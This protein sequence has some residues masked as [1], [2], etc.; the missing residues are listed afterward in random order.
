MR[1][2]WIE[3][4][5]WWA[6]AS[7]VLMIIGAFGPWAKI[8]PLSAIPLPGPPPPGLPDITIT[9]SGTDA[10]DGWTIVVLAL[11]GGAALFAGRLLRLR[12]GPLVAA[13]AGAV[14]FGITIYDNSDLASTVDRTPLKNFIDP[15]WGVFLALGAS[16]SLAVAS[17]V[18]F[19]LI[20]LQQQPAPAAVEPP[21][22]TG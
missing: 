2:R 8:K 1:G 14:S 6:A 3:P 7:A 18:L 17:G 4:A 11:V 13:A 9:I 16:V 19:W 12:W 22:A 10:G 21:A 20:R 5:F 15:G